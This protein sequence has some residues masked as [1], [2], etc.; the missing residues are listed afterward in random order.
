MGFTPT[1]HDAF[2]K[3]LMSH[4]ETARDFL[5]IHLP[6]ALLHYC[7][8]KTLTLTS[9]SFIEENL[10]ASHSDMLYALKTQNGAGYI[11]CLI[12]HQSSP[13]PQMSFRLMRYAI[14]AM[15]QHLDAGHKTLPL[16]I[17]I[18]FYHGRVTPYPYAM[19]WLKAF[20]N[21]ELAGQLYGNDFPLV[22]ITT[23]SDDK[24][25]THRRVAMLELL[26][27]HIRIRDM[28]ELQ[29]QIIK[30]LNS[31]Y[32]TDK[33]LPVLINYMLHVGETPDAKSLISALAQRSSQHKEK[34][35]TMAEQLRLEGLKKGLTEGLKKGEKKGLT[36]GLK[37]GEKKGKLEVARNMLAGGLDFATVVKMTGLPEKT[38]KRIS[39]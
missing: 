32:V 37:K 36:E 14:A 33:L 35:M 21:P 15:Q 24:I 27:K 13:D 39:H 10:R 25:I 3:Q 7:N 20:A 11:Y 9:G 38:L 29:E 5:Q 2:F 23:V 16:V 30:I 17:P 6:A 4:V 8:L 26:Q 31:G 12:E 22:D 28:A 34:L 19:N 18:L 1:P